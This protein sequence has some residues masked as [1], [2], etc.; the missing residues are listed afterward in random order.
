MFQFY[1]Y[2]GLSTN[3]EEELIKYKVKKNKLR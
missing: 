2:P 1:R 3:I